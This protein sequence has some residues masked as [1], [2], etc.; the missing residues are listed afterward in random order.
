MKHGNPNDRYLTAPQ[1]ADYLKV[2]LSWIRKKTASGEL[3]HVKLGSRVVYV[4]DD[5]DDFME[6][7][8]AT[9]S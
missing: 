3:P 2:S 4:R 7:R 9:G 1:A 6:R 5:L 8:R